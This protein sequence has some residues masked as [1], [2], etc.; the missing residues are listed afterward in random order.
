M[1]RVRKGNDI[2]I[3]WEIFGEIDGV[4]SPYDLVGKDITLY[5]GTPYGK[6]EVI[7]FST[8]QNMIIWSF[9]GKD[10]KYIGVHTL[11]LV[12]NEGEAFMHTI[13]EC[14]A[15]EIISQTCIKEVE[16]KDNLRI[17]TQF[18]IGAITPDT[19]LDPSSLNVVTNAAICEALNTFSKDVDNSIDVFKGDV[20]KEFDTLSKTI[21]LNLSAQ[22][23]QIAINNEQQNARITSAM[24]SQDALIAEGLQNM[25]NTLTAEIQKVDAVIAEQNINIQQTTEALHEQIDEEFA[26]QNKEIEG[27]VSY[28]GKYPELTAGF[29][30]N[31]VGR[32]EAIEAKINFRPTGSGSIEDGAARMK[33]LKG[34]AVVWN[35]LMPQ[36][37]YWGLQFNNDVFN[38][39]YIDGKYIVT[40]EDFTSTQG[41]GTA[42]SFIISVSVQFIASHRYLFIADLKA[43]YNTSFICGLYANEQYVFINKGHVSPTEC[44]YFYTATESFEGTLIRYDAEMPTDLYEKANTLE[45]TPRIIDLT[46]MFG[47][48][49][50]PT[51]IEEFYARMPIGVDMYAYNEGEVIPMA[52]DGI[53]SVGFNAWDEEWENGVFNTTTGENS[54]IGGQLDQIRSKNLIDVLPNTEYYVNMPS[55]LGDD[56]MWVMLFDKEK[57]I[58]KD[59]NGSLGSVSG[60]SFKVLSY[61]NVFKTAPNARYM[62][63]YMPIG[64]GATYKNDICIHLVHTGY[65]N[66]EY[67]PYE[68]DIRGIDPRIKE[69]FPDGMMSVGTTY[70]KVYNRN[71]K[72]IIEKWIGEVDLGDCS[73]SYDSAN[74]SFATYTLMEL[75]SHPSV[76]EDRNK[77]LMCAKYAPSIGLVAIN[78]NDKSWLRIPKSIT[79]KDTAYTDAESFKA[80]MQGIPLYYELAEPVITEYDEPFN[81][82]Y[83]VW[84][85]GTEEMLADKPSAPIKADIIY[86]FNAVDSIRNNKLNIDDLL[87]RMAQLENQIAAIS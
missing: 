45:L 5:L 42:H 55:S 38:K 65:K 9:R 58:I 71:G 51:T 77:G 4:V 13:D 19:K 40:C 31:L 59:Y 81:L 73:W 41:G 57:N 75:M 79:I 63:F 83:L 48:G 87:K 6:E 16:C 29:A 17:S 46:K 61:I 39:Q 82:D 53:K 15:F 8:E 76:T 49:N 36:S 70:D 32:G 27:K 74:K 26:K 56:G 22:N 47:A 1:K 64:Y 78:M 50:E 28:D 52:A 86:Q 30:S 10:Q 68:Y 84:D 62:K 60:Y 2:N 35:Q 69:A 14:Q 33:A 11:T 3:L 72:G 23:D 25:N 20:I 54:A 80:A 7:D 12:V 24:A 67:K 44:I 43:K 18:N 37:M 21:Q 66:G 85:F 34:N